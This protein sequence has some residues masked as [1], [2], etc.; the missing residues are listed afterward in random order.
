ML[1]LP[2][3]A[4]FLMS[5]PLAFAD[6]DVFVPIYSPP[7]TTGGGARTTEGMLPAGSGAQAPK[8]PAQGA[9]ALRPSAPSPNKEPIKPCQQF[10]G[11]VGMLQ[12]AANAM[13]TKPCIPNKG[14]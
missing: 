2:L 13:D 7:L 9:E 3:A 12:G 10:G 5:C 14:K 6:D 8:A 1:A 4:T 11:F